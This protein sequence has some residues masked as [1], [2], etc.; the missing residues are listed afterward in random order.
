MYGINLVISHFD[1]SFENE[2]ALH[3]NLAI[4]GLHCI[5][6]VTIPLDLRLLN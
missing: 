2:Y 3:Y 5:D 4:I 6:F 1:F